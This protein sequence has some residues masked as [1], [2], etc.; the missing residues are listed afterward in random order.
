MSA[1]QDY[2]RLRIGI[3]WARELIGAEP[4]YFRADELRLDAAG[5]SL[6]DGDESRLAE[7]K[8]DD[9]FV[10]ELRTALHAL[11]D[12]VLAA[13]QAAAVV[14]CEQFLASTQGQP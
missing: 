14:E 6:W 12:R 5:L 2:E 1:V 10:G 13:Q 8:V 9:Q 4:G 11:F 7:L 3:A